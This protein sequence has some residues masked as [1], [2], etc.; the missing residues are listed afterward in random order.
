MIIIDFSS[1][2]TRLCTGMREDTNYSKER[3]LVLARNLTIQYIL[4]LKK[5]Y[6]KEYGTNIVLAIDSKDGYWRKRHFE[7]YKANREYSDY[8]NWEN[9]KYA[10]T[11]LAA[12]LE[13]V[14]PFRVIKV[15]LAEGDDVIGVL[16]KYH[17][18]FGLHEPCLVVS[19]DGDFFQLLKYDSVAYYSLKERKIVSKSR[20]EVDRLITESIVKGQ[21][22]DG[23]PNIYSPDD[24]FVNADRPRQK[25]VYEKDILRFVEKG[26]SACENDEQKK[27]YLRNQKMYDFDYIDDDVSQAIIAKYEAPREWPYVPAVLHKYL[28]AKR[29]NILLNRLEEF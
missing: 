8:I 26:I 3:A 15:P 29:S 1:L 11:T 9:V 7:H 19:S 23:Y 5:K 25:A 6:K 16:V 27:N 21:T 12:E 10:S 4:D 2:V 24:Q 28:T 20:E 18:Q 14:S 17:Q 22:G 13:V